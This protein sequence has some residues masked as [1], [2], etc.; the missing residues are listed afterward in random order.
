LEVADGKTLSFIGGPRVF[1]TETGVTVP[2]GVSMS[3][4]SLSA[5]NGLIYMATVTSPGEVPVPTLSGSPLGSPGSPSSGPAVIRIRSGEFVMDRA[6][7]IAT[8]TSNTAQS[9]I[10]INVQSSLELRNVSSISTKTLTS[11]YGSSV[12]INILA[13]TLTLKNGS[14]VDTSVASGATGRGGDI[15]IQVRQAS[16]HGSTIKSD[17]EGQGDAGTISIRGNDSISLVDSAVVST[18]TTFPVSTSNGGLIRL[19]SPRIEVKG[20]Q[21]LSSTDGPGN[22]GSILIETQNLT[23]TGAG[24]LND[25]S[26]ISARTEG[27]GQAG[28]ITIR[29]TDG[30][31]SHA[32]DMILSGN[33]QIV[34]ETVSSVLTLGGN[35]GSVA[36]DTARL[37]LGKSSGISTASSGTAPSGLS[38]GNAGNITVNATDAV[39]VFG[40][41]ITTSTETS[42]RV[43]IITINTGTLN[44][45]GGGQLTSS[46]F[47]TAPAGAVII[48]GVQ[49]QGSMANSVTISGKGE[50]GNTSGI[51]TNTKG[52]GSG[53]NISVNANSITLQKDGMLS[54]ETS[55]TAASAIGGTITVN[56]NQVQL[57]SGGSITANSAGAADAGNIDVSAT[58]GL[59]MQ[60]G[61]SITTRVVLNA[62]GSTARGGDI[63]VT[64]SPTATVNIQDSTISASVP[65]SG[66]GG[67]V[68]IDPYF[69]ILQNGRILSQT[70]QGTGG[71]IKITARVFLPDAGTVISADATRG[72]NGTVT[73]EAPRSKLRGITELNSEDFSEGEANP[74]ASYGECQVQSPYAPAGGKI[75]PMVN[76]P[77]QATLL[78]NQSCAAVA[79]GQFSS[80]TVAGNRLLIEPGEWL[81]S[82]LTLAISGSHDDTRNNKRLQTSLD[83]P[84]GERSLLSLRQIA[85]PG[86][87]IKAFAAP[88]SANCAS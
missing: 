65:G 37:S 26:A 17:T 85:P 64:T 24:D 55:G 80:F 59:T 19:H 2:S 8:T 44:L 15:A 10:E 23:V 31:G 54:A 63:T 38:P 35:A 21:I 41:L 77:L 70:D 53:G 28:Q 76:R 87:L 56:S 30:L 32:Q 45:T 74:V 43:G 86:F 34:S 69:V 73:N 29:E 14:T 40:G 25:F 66:D 1:T 9:P 78:L 36:I 3:G 39:T 79:G 72:V 67:N 33:S 11:G 22:A 16:L 82:P 42:G 81:S 27:P 49:G 18:A 13:D 12:A 83:E 84:M 20:S 62:T 50:F 68:T 6:L 75:Q 88:S 47:L 71:N 60:N 51:F 4:G 48:Q 7:L 46:S 57:E 5:P 52:S 61:S 58:N